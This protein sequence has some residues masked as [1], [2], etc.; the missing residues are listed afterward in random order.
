MTYNP[1]RR[2]MGLLPQRPL[3]VGTVI[4]VSGGVATIQLPGGATDTAR[5]DVSVN[6][7]VYF[8]DGVIEGPAPNL[9]LEI[10][11]I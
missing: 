2:L 10:I 11:E 1:Y 8:R 7:R 9:P 3:M 6:D 5:G 4:A